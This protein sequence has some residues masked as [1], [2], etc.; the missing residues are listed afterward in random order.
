M[1]N[2]TRRQNEVLELLAQGRKPIEIADILF[3]EKR[4]VDFH[5]RNI[6]KSLGVRNRVEAGRKYWESRENGVQ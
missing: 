6:Y 5:L 4:T 3:V 2:L 1:T